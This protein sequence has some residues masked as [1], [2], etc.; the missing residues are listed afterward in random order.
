[1]IALDQLSRAEL[2]LFVA[3]FPV[4]GLLLIETKGNCS[5]K[6]GSLRVAFP[7]AA[8][9]GNAT[10]FVSWLTRCHG[11]KVELVESKERKVPLT[12]EWVPDQLLNELLVSMAK[13]ETDNRRTPALVFCFNRDGGWSV[14]KQRKGLPLLS[15]D[16]S[17]RLHAEVN[18]LD[19]TQGVGPKIR[20]ML[21]RGVGV[22]HAGMLP[23]YRRVVEDLFN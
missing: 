9:V 11:R 1:M 14:A 16:Q 17:T 7:V 10:E 2:T 13:G 23:K 12:Y 4:M 3:N 18:R 21:H 15:G 5:I 20:Q 19:W 6:N 8:T 22:H